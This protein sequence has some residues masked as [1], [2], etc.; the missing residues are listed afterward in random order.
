MSD[1]WNGNTSNQTVSFKALI[2]ANAI[3]VIIYTTAPADTR[4]CTTVGNLNTSNVQILQADTRFLASNLY[5]SIYSSFVGI[6]DSKLIVKGDIEYMN[7]LIGTTGNV[8]SC[9]NMIN[10][11]LP[12]NSSLVYV[13][14][15]VGFAIGAQL[16]TTRSKTT[17]LTLASAQ[18]C[19]LATIGGTGYH[20][21]TAGI[22]DDIN[23]C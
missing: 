11:G 4:E 18:W 22:I 1:T 20:V 8:D 17:T 23:A 16:Y 9:G 21:T 13:S 7:F 3:G 14:P 6:S 2:N 12:V 15:S 5:F 19:A 10:A